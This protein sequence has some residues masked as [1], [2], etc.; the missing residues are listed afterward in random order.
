LMVFVLAP[1]CCWLQM[2]DCALH[3]RF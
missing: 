1:M 2:C 3:T